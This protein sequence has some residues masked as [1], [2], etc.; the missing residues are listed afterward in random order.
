MA[1]GQY[2]QHETI[3]PATPPTL[4]S[5]ANGYTMS[6]SWVPSLQWSSDAESYDIKIAENSIFTDSEVNVEDYVGAPPVTTVAITG[7]VGNDY[8]TSGETL[9]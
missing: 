3:Y 4:T 6:A 2:I 9:Y 1:E 8:I 7:I 5:P